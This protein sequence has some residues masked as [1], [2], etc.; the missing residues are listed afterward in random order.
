MEFKKSVDDIIDS[1]NA[2]NEVCEKF[3]SNNGQS[4]LKFLEAGI[5][6]L[7]NENAILKDDN[8]SKF[9]IIESLTTCQCSWTIVNNENYT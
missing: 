1:L 4:K 2:K 7:R 8:K 5:L 9:K 3:G 6:K